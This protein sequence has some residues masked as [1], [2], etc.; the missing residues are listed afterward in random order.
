MVARI[1]YHPQIIDKG[2]LTYLP[3]NGKTTTL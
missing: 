3:D 2:L 1:V